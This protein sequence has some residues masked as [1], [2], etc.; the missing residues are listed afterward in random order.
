MPTPEEVAR[1]ALTRYAEEQHDRGEFYC[2]HS[3]IQFRDEHYPAPPKRVRA[4][5]Q[6]LDGS[7][8]AVWGYSTVGLYANGDPMSGVFIAR[9]DIATLA[10]LDARADAEGFVVADT[11]F[12]DTDSQRCK[13]VASDD[14]PSGGTPVLPACE[15]GHGEAQHQVPGHGNRWCRGCLCGDYEAR[16]PESADSC[17]AGESTPAFTP[18]YETRVWWLRWIAAGWCVLSENTP[19]TLSDIPVVPHASLDAL[20]LQLDELQ[21]SRGDVEYENAE[22]RQERDRWMETAV[23]L[24]AQLV[25]ATRDVTQE[26]FEEVAKKVHD[27]RQLGVSW[28][29]YGNGSKEWHRRLV[30]DTIK[31]LGKKVEGA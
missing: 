16:T 17:N 1:E 27:A 20:R 9:S 15:C 21:Q 13:A 29:N 8:R 11:S 3:A 14:P 24:R 4:E 31:A 6:L 18:A 10:A 28:D 22:L 2:H 19:P 12:S 7:A 23:T 26:E 30:R 5:V 25:E